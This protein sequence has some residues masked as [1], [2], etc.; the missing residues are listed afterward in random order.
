LTQKAIDKRFNRSKYDAQRVL[1]DFSETVRDETDLER[2]SARLLQ[3]VNETMQPKSLS[4]W[5]KKDKSG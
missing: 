3:V 5:L 4:V 2:L 1:M